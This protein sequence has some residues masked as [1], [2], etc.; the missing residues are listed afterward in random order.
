MANQVLP[1]LLLSHGQVGR[2][3]LCL[4]APLQSWFL[5]LAAVV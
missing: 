1:W 2:V 5:I 4:D 3:S